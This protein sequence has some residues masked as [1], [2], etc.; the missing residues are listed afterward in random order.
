MKRLLAILLLLAVL[1]PVLAWGGFRLWLRSQPDEFR[2]QI[3]QFSTVEF[4]AVLRENFAP[5]PV[6][7]RSGY[8]R[9]VVPGRGHAP[10][11]LRTSL[12]GR[13]RVL[14]IALAPE[15]WLA[16]ATET[17]SIHRLWR[18]TIAFEG[19]VHDARHGREPTGQGA[20]YLRPPLES[21]WRIETPT[22]W[23]PAEVVW[24]GHGVEAATGA[25]WLRYALRA[26]DGA[27]REMTEWPEREPHV[28]PPGA[29]LERRFELDPGP[30]VALRA[31]TALAVHDGARREDD[32]L[33]FAPDVRRA[34]LVHRFDAPRSSAAAPPV[35]VAPETDDPFAATDCRTCHGERERIVGPAWSEIAARYAGIERESSAT[36][37]VRRVREGGGGRWGDTVMPPHPDLS[38]AEARRLVEAILDTPP[39]EAPTPVVVTDGAEAT[40]TFRTDTLPPPDALHPSLRSTP[41]DPPDFSPRV[42][43][44][45]WLPDGRLAVATWDRDGAVFAIDGWDG[46]PAA[47]RIERIAQGLHE[48][49]GLTSVGDALYVMQKQEITRLVDDDGDGWRETWLAV[50]NDW[51][52]TSNFHE[53]G[54]GL[55][56][57]DGHLYASLSACVLNG[58]KSCPEQTPDRG[59]VIRVRI[60]GEVEG[61]PFPRPIERVAAGFR[62][63]NGLAVDTDGALHVTD[64]QGDWLP[65]SKLIR[66]RPGAHYGWRGPS[67][68]DVPPADPPAL[69]LPQNEVGNS[70]TQPLFLADGPYA[71]QPIFGDVYNGGLKRACLEQVDGVAQGAAFHFSGGFEAPINRLLAAP[72]GGFVVGQIGLS[73]NWGEYGKERHGL[74]RV[75]WTTEPAFEAYCVRARPGG[76]AIEW[77]RPVAADLEPTPADVRLRDWFY[78]PSPVYGGPKY[79]LRRLDVARVSL[80]DDRRVL[81]IDVPALEPGRVVHLTFA[82]RFRSER[83]ERPWVREAWYTLNALLDER[84]E[85]RETSRALE[86]SEA[87]EP[88]ETRARSDETA[89]SAP[90][91]PPTRTTAAAP[92]NTLTAEER[93]AGWRLL[94]DGRSF[95]GW[96]RYGSDDDP[97]PH[98]VIDDDALHFTR[99]V[100][101]AGL[102]W[103]HLNPFVPAALD[104]ST[105]ERF[106]DFELSID[107]RVV[108]GGNSGI[109]YLVPDEST[110][111]A[112]DL[113]PEMQVLDD[114][115]HA[116]GRK[117]RR[118]AGDLY[119]VQSLAHGAARPAGEWNTARIR[120]EGDRIRHWL[121]GVPTVDIVRGGPE[122]DAAV[123]RSKF[124]DVPGWG[125]ARRGHIALQDHGDPVW[126]RNVKL[127]SLGAPGGP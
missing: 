41:L 24:R 30:A 91:P 9:R 121:N 112:W 29:G 35:P 114:A 61:D 80:S 77:T 55:V 63:P 67:A 124:A 69:W 102:V 54:F 113:A 116:D 3:E 68:T 6:V 106:D 99:D 19:P 71:G 2:A 20:D 10:W 92:P 119:D 58:G 122:W 22:G 5:A 21:A 33:V 109:F 94:F 18:G 37:L 8:D 74:E 93:A 103:N 34:R 95:A 4:L 42:G 57:H 83:G 88:F 85:A 38:H 1:L 52:T 28:V 66:V 13:P 23:Q 123:A 62:T 97:R 64:N 89:R 7:D 50:A 79:D 31:P 14:A 96:K 70:P 111:L 56:A 53:F 120:V 110:A 104:L 82:E 100:S 32:R 126:F 26:P 98:W 60:E 45:A 51:S 46:D 125:R 25:L 36:Q 43:G 17:A 39:G 81:E 127:R 107:W 15:L 16:Y 118:R 108:P 115:R 84:L 12:D 75:S 40:W 27:I 47:L 87:H 72:G 90:T 76:F 73:G 49:L 65:A 11:L 86:G 59:T 117:P 105:V 48:P 101:F 78:V 44:L